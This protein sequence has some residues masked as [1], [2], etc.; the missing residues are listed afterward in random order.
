VD[1]IIDLK[2]IG[3]QNA[4]LGW[5]RALLPLDDR[6]IWVGFTRVRKTEFMEE[7]SLDQEYFPRGHG[8]E[9]HAY[10][11]LLTLWISDASGME[12]TLCSVSFPAIAQV[13]ELQRVV[14][15]PSS[16]GLRLP[17]VDWLGLLPM[18]FGLRWAS[19]S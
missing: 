6:R 18:V 9:A 15:I 8:G 19:L 2:Q 5:C 17:Q 16:A 10:R 7:C 1:E 12:S 11:A 13:N 3:D 14:S 4:L